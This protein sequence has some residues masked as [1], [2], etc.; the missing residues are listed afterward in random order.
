MIIQDIYNVLPDIIEQGMTAIIVE[1]DISRAMAVASRFYC[2]QEGHVS[3]EGSTD[4]ATHEQ[5]TA[6]YFGVAV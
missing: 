1:Q 6:A 4:K 5:I 3:L 2:L